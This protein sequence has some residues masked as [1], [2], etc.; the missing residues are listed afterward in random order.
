MPLR[1]FKCHTL[2]FPSYDLAAT[3]TAASS[4]QLT[5]KNGPPGEATPTAHVEYATVAAT[6]TTS[7]VTAV[8]TLETIKV[9]GIAVISPT[10]HQFR[11]RRQNSAGFGVWSNYVTAT[12][13]P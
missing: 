8:G 3:T 2:P 5:F 7:T 6:A 1:Y 9:T 13:T 10:V 12:V 4:V 11:L